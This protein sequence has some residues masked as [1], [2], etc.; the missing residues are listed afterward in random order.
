[1]LWGLVFPN[2]W[3]VKLVQL[4]IENFP[5]NK[6]ISVNRDIEING[7]KILKGEIGI[8]K[9]ESEG[10]FSIQIIRNN[11]S[12]RL[13]RASFDLFDMEKI[14]DEYEKKV[15]NV[16][17]RLLETT[18]FAKNQHGKN[19]RVVRRPSCIECRVQIDGVKLT[20]AQKRKWEKIK[21]N[22]DL[23]ECP[24]CRKITVPGL[25]SKIVLD[26]DHDSGHVRGW[27]CDSCN[28][29]IGRFKDDVDILERAI[30]YLLNPE[31][32]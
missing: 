25:T 16:C 32:N 23:F 13:S 4:S 26:H 29:G 22:Y 5:K 27:I 6:F 14:G 1:M 10:L 3:R 21:P 17:H 31:E 20:A 8:V 2:Y 30:N 9:S 19:D 28:T 18:E 15:C 7:Y 24:I 11:K 12:L